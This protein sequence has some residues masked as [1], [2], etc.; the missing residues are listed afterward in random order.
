[1]DGQCLSEVTTHQRIRKRYLN[2]IGGAWVAPRVQKFIAHRSPSTDQDCCEIARSNAQ[3]MVFA[4]GAAHGARTTWR[5][6]APMERRAKLRAITAHLQ[7]NTEFLAKVEAEASGKLK[8][9]SADVEIAQAIGHFRYA[10]MAFR[11]QND[12]F[13]RTD[14]GVCLQSLPASYALVVAAWAISQALVAGET[15]VL[16]PHYTASVP[17]LA[18]VDLIAPFLAAGSVNVV[19][20][21]DHEIEDALGFEEGGVDSGAPLHPI[22][23]PPNAKPAQIFFADVCDEVDGFQM[24]AIESFCLFA[25]NQGV[26]AFAPTRAFVHKDIYDRFLARALGT[27]AQLERRNVAAQTSWDI[28]ERTRSYVQIARNEGAVL[29]VGGRPR[30]PTGLAMQATVFEGQNDMRVFQERV[31]GPILSVAPFENFEQGLAMVNDTQSPIAAGVWSRNRAT[32]ARFRAECN[33]PYVWKNSYYAYPQHAAF[34][35]FQQPFLSQTP[36]ECPRFI[37]RH[38]LQVDC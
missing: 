28:H 38:L 18:L 37:A 17:V 25:Q 23:D 21:F 33:A 36:Q 30:G 10:S 35:G 26:D 32:T 19:T 15:I 6:V 16:K 13:F 11:S 1:M 20:G 29:R 27:L 3:D 34:D 12:S 5:Q 9:R 14:Q 4:L 8:G 22:N 31:C 24:R 2:F 7:A